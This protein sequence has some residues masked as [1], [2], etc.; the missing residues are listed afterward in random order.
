MPHIAKDS[1]ATIHFQCTW[2]S[3]HAS[4]VDRYLAQDVSFTRDILP[5]GIKSRMLGL[6]VGDSVELMIDPAE[7]PPF[8]PGKVLDLPRERFTPPEIH[9]R[10]IKPRIGRFYPKH[11]IKDV[12]GTRPDSATPFRVVA[13]D[14]AWFKADLNHTMAGREV[15]I[16]ATVLDIQPAQGQ[17]GRLTRWP[18]VMLNG[19]GMQARLPET[20]TDFLGADPFL[21]DDEAGDSAFYATPRTTVHLDS[22][23]VTNVKTIYEGVLDETMDVLDLMAGSHSHLPD[24][25]KPAS[26]TGLGLDKGAME[27]N[28]ALTR[29]I[30]HDLNQQPVLP[31]KDGEFDAV[32]C[33]VSVE[34][35]TKPFEVFEEVARVLKPGGVFAVTFSNRWF[36]PKVI[37]VWTELHEFERM[38]LVSQYMIRSE[39]FSAVT[40]V[41][42]RGW[43]RPGDKGDRYAAELTESDPVYAVL[44][45]KRG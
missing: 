34:Y 1:L 16:K 14:K 40:T 43:P 5:L 33:T 37:R 32:L 31:F 17:A 10:L 4:H 23:A 2:S 21:R 27:D 24:R 15:S 18:E 45:R 28:P 25:F 9:G 35:M 7:V 44:G 22:R 38:G 19:P 41:S 42:E 36:P 39:A 20:P 13:V 3:S 6:G 11:F 12:P 26:M 8:K 30:I 29:R